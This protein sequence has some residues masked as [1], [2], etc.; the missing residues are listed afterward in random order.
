MRKAKIIFWLLILVILAVV[1][2]QNQDLFLNEQY[3]G[4]NLLVKEYH[5]DNIPN[6]IFFFAFFLMGLLIACFSSLAER[7]KSKKT[8]KILN[9]AID[10]HHQEMSQLQKEVASLKTGETAETEESDQNSG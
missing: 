2:Y 9:A 5:A 4:I 7:F 1:F 3:I 8:I 10:S 6:A